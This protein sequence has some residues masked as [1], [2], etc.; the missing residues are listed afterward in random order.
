[1]RPN[2]NLIQE[3]YNQMS[4]N[5]TNQAP[6]IQQANTNTQTV[7]QQNNAIPAS[8]PIVDESV[9][10]EESAE[11]RASG[12]SDSTANGNPSN[13][14]QVN[15]QNTITPVYQP[16]VNEN[17]R[18]QESGED[19]RKHIEEGWARWINRSP[20]NRLR[21]NQQNNIRPASQPPVNVNDNVREEG[22][23][24][25]RT[26]GISEIVTNGNPSNRLEVNRQNNTIPSLQPVV[27]ENARKEESAEDRR[28]LLRESWFNHKQSIKNSQPQSIINKTAQQN[29]C[30]SLF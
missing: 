22:G 28:Q 9:R 6:Q 23:T 8:Q 24:E 16:I 21:V 3:L 13:D 7:V 15:Q 17:A 19:M 14:L 29:N 10:Q 20:S 26:R 2:N 18:E 30:C 25:G 4:H 27:N 12:I 1:M 5:Q 11:D